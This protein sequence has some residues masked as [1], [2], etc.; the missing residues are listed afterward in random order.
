MAQT[1]ASLI[2]ID[3]LSVDSTV[4]ETSHAHVALLGADILIVEN[5][6]GL[7]QL[8]PRTVYQF[9]FLPLLLAEVDGAPVRAVAWES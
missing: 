8:K 1:G 2:G 4:Q 6:T 3:A 7:H 5:L 9:S